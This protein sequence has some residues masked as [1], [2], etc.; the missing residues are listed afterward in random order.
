MGNRPNPNINSDEIIKLANQNTPNRDNP[1]WTD[2]VTKLNAS[3][4]NMMR[5]NLVEYITNLA[6]Q[7]ITS[8]NSVLEDIVKKSVGEQTPEGGE[9][10]NDYRER[11]DVGN[12]LIG[13][14]ASAAKAHA[15]GRG[16]TASGISSHA[17]G[18]ETEASGH[19]SHAQGN[20]TKALG[21]QNHAEGRETTADGGYG[22]HAEGYQTSATGDLGPHSEGYKTSAQGDSSHA[23]GNNTLAKGLNTHAEG[24]STQA[25]GPHSHVEGEG[26]ISYG[27]AN[28]AEGQNTLAGALDGTTT[29]VAAAHAEGLDSKAIGSASHAEGHGSEASGK[30]SHAE[31]F[32][33]S[34]SGEGAHSEGAFGDGAKGKYSHTG[35]SYSAVYEDATCGFAHGHVAKVSHPYSTA[36]GVQ[37]K[38]DAENQTIIGAYNSTSKDSANPNIFAIGNGSSDKRQNAFEVLQDGSANLYKQGK[39]DTAVI[40]KKTLD[41]KIN[42]INDAIQDIL[43]NIS[44]ALHFRGIFESIE[45][46]ESKLTDIVDG[47]VIIVTKDSTGDNNTSNEYVYSDGN[48]EKLGD[49]NDFMLKSTAEQEFDAIDASLSDMNN[50]ISDINKALGYLADK[51][52]IVSEPSFK[53]SSSNVNAVEVGTDLTPNFIISFDAGEYEYGPTPTGSEASEYEVTFNTES[54]NTSSGTFT[55]VHVT[56]S[57]SLTLSAKCSYSDGAIP[58]NNLGLDYPEGKIAGATKTITK[59]LKGYRQAFAGGASSKD[60]L[61][62]N[63]T[64][65]DIRSLSAKGNN[66]KTFNV[67]ISSSDIRVIIAFPDSWGILKSAND[68]NDSNKNIVSAFG[69]A[70][71]IKVSGLK[72]NEDMMDYKVYVMDFASAYGGEGNTYEITIG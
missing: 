63:L 5:R 4:M 32:K 31:G 6:K 45:D 70:N 17:E 41:D 49:A 16:T 24:L 61:P 58:K 51:N 38:T 11:Q 28:H 60:I 34:A 72:P 21:M 25:L 1:L 33:T 69:Q 54:L 71:I 52:V 18:V 30:A 48:W 67:S 57:T 19:T 13:N 12:G 15:E 53:F 20:N 29:A 7:I 62:L 50:S 22:A 37:V 27:Q 2:D 55:S 42:P 66:K 9:I 43:Q 36:I 64:S 10:F 8:E 59:T 68:V 44:N 47:D 26:S 39:E 14:I 3:N 23:E 56:D 65:I 40:I 46:A 35:G